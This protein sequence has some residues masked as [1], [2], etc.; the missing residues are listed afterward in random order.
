MH[1]WSACGYPCMSIG[2]YMWYFAMEFCVRINTSL[3]NEIGQGNP[4]N[5]CFNRE[6]GHFAVTHNIGTKDLFV[7]F[8]YKW[9]KWFGTFIKSLLD[10]EVYTAFQ[11]HLFRPRTGR[12]IVSSSLRL[13]R[14][15][16]CWLGCVLKSPQISIRI[17]PCDEKCDMLGDILSLIMYPIAPMMRKPIPTAWEI[18][19]NSRRSAVRG[20]Y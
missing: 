18:L 20:R 15:I 14:L 12:T 9:Y 4:R 11:K 2:S 19:M 16:C 6:F 1:I 8:G 3:G 10:I 13:H 7:E 5:C 17:F